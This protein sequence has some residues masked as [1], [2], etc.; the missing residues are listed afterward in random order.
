[1]PISVV[2]PI[3][4]KKIPVEKGDIVAEVIDDIL[5]VVCKADCDEEVDDVKEK[6]LEQDEWLAI[7]HGHPVPN[8][9]TTDM[10][11]SE[12]VSQLRQKKV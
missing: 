7:V 1:M 2:K 11:Q 9:D 4:P 12:G 3:I 10:K 8:D 6:V 5:N